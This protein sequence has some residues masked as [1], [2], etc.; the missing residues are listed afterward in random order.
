MPIMVGV[1]VILVAIGRGP[2]ILEMP[3]LILSFSAGVTELG[4][5]M[6]A[7]ELRVVEVVKG[8]GEP[9]VILSRRRIWILKIKRVCGVSFGLGP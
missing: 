2:T 6:S 8:C 1:I 5:L 9:G 7:Y 3:L 4:C